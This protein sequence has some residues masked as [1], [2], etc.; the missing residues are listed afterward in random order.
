MEYKITL[1]EINQV[2]VLLGKIPAKYSLPV[3]DLLKL[4]IEN[5]QAARAVEAG[6]EMSQ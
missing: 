4:F 3:I 5:Q 6:S 1:E 2:V